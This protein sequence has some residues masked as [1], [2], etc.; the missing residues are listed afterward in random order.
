MRMRM[1]T[2][3]FRGY[4]FSTF[5]HWSYILDFRPSVLLYILQFFL[6]FLFSCFSS[7]PSP[8]IQ[9]STSL[10][11]PL[12]TSPWRRQLRPNAM[13]LQP[14]TLQCFPACKK[15]FRRCKSV[16]FSGYTEAETAVM[17]EV[18]KQ[19]LCSPNDSVVRIHFS[20]WSHMAEI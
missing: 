2:R 20:I 11:C 15:Q 12:L 14:V 9:V 17:L 4:Y 19:G 3:G 5:V 6:I 1:R 16:H 8:W 7:L 18:T 10:T 13:W